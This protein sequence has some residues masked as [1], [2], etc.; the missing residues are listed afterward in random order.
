MTEA[1]AAL[2]Q[3]GAV[4]I[5][6]VISLLALRSLHAELAAERAAR[7][8]DAKDSTQLLIQLQKEILAAV[9]KLSDLYASVQEERRA[10]RETRRGPR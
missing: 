7:I 6:L 1:L 9:D 10:E 5:I 8:Q 2:V 4:G 3:Y